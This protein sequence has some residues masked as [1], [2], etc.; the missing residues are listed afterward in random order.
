M[1]SPTPVA[2]LARSQKAVP[3]T[4]FKDGYQDFANWQGYRIWYSPETGANWAGPE[5]VKK[6]VPALG[7]ATSSEKWVTGAKRV[8][9]QRGVM[10]WQ[11]FVGVRVYL[12]Q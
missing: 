9:F 4:S 1:V 5:F 7:L 6:W 11:P 12:T 10:T 2:D 3:K 8:T